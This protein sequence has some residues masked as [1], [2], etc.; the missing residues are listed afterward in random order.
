MKDCVENL[1]Y[2]MFPILENLST[3]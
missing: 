1:I 3:K 2:K